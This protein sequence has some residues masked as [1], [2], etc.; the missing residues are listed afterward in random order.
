LFDSTSGNGLTQS[1]VVLPPNSCEF[2]QIL[3]NLLRLRRLKSNA[4][5]Y[6]ATS[7]ILAKEE[8][9]EKEKDSFWGNARLESTRRQEATIHAQ[10]QVLSIM[11][12]SIRPNLPKKH[13]RWSTLA[14]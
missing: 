12:R 11:I 8:H 10:T 3:A 6:M 9:A 5:F 13:T 14:V 7:V 4:L 1:L 2:S